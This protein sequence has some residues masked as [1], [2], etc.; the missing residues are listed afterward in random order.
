MRR[1][2]LNRFRDCSG[3]SGTGRVLEG[4][5][6][7]SGKVVVEWKGDHHS[8][9]VYESIEEFFFVHSHGD[10]AELVWID[11]NLN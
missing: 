5:L 8:I 1:F 9:G 3:I 11:E 4:V 10:S 2:Y 6:F 7:P